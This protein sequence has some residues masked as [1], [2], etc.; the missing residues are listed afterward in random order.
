MKDLPHRDMCANPRTKYYL[1]NMRVLIT[2]TT[3]KTSDSGMPMT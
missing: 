3:L 1:R 2:R